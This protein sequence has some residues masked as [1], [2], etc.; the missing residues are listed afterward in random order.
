MEK[1]TVNKITKA[2]LIG[3]TVFTLATLLAYFSGFFHTKVPLEAPTLYEVYEGELVEAVVHAKP[4]VEEISGTVQATSDTI[5][6]ARILANILK[7]NVHAGDQVQERELL[8]ELD[9]EA[10]LAAREQRTQ[11]TAAA[12]AVLEDAQLNRNRTQSLRDSGSVS[13][14]VLD[15][16]TTAHRQA[17]ADH[18]R[19]LRAAAEAEAAIGYTQIRAPMSGTVVE[20]FAEPGD[21]ATPGQPLLKLFNPG[22]MRIEATVRE[23]LIRFVSLGDQL[24]AEIDA[25]DSY[26]S[27]I[28]DEIVPSANPISRTFLLKARLKNID[29]LFPGMF[30]RLFIPTAT[31]E[32]IWIDSRAIQQA[33]QLR[34]VYVRGPQGD[35]RRFVRLGQESGELVEVRSG[36][37]QGEMVVVLS[38]E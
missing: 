30:A 16:A 6:A 10:L 27:A 31:T 18:E 11:V 23:S 15:R 4:A 9:D 13:Q 25:L 22:Q 8:I 34:F 17:S 37:A 2:F 19:A 26:T 12:F 3:V 32:R 7:I 35:S 28:I 29:G 1:E 24:G 5:I 14:A 20:R 38:T 36:L 21:V 33:G